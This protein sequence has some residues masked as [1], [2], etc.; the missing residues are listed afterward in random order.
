MNIDTW[1]NSFKQYWTQHD[2]ESVL[3]LFDLNVDYYETPFHKLTTRKDLEEA[4]NGIHN[5][6]DIELDLTV[7]NQN[8]NN[9]SVIWYLEYTQKGIVKKC[10]G[11]YLITLNNENK[12]TY[13]FHCCESK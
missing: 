6:Q 10:A 4:W 11:S 7:F 3:S 13:F 9:Y 1:L 8:Q 5:Q 2:V 12:C